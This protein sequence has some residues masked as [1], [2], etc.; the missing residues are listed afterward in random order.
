MMEIVLLAALCLL[1][2]VVGVSVL[3]W[4]IGRAR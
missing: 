4:V 1:G 3:A 2:S